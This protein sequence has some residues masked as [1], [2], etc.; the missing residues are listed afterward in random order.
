MA[1]E[2]K[3]SRTDISTKR[4]KLVLENRLQIYKT[5][6]GVYYGRKML[7][8]F[9]HLLCDKCDFLEIYFSKLL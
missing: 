2:G 8:Y 7:I 6:T 3:W 1:F 5:S 9:V 4:V